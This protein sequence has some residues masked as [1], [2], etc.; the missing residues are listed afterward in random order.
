M[1]PAYMSELFAKLHVDPNSHTNR[2]P[3]N[4]HPAA[5]S[6]T[7]LPPSTTNAGELLTR[8]LANPSLPLNPDQSIA[9]LSHC[10][11]LGDREAQKAQGKRIV[12]CIGNT[13]SGKSTFVNYLSGCTMQRVLPSKLG[14]QDGL[15][16]VVIVKPV[17]QGGT[18]DEVAR[19]G[20]STAS[21]TFMPQVT[22][23]RQKYDLD[24][25]DCP[26]FIDNR[27]VEIN[28]A[29]AANIHRTLV[30]A[31][32]V[33]V[34]VLVHYSALKADKVRGL[35]DTIQ[36]CCSLFG[37]RENLIKNADSILF[38]VS[39]IPLQDIQDDDEDSE[40]LTLD[41]LRE[42]ILSA[43]LTNQL[44]KKVL[45]CL[46][47]NLFI[48]DPVESKNLKFEGALRRD[49]IVKRISELSDIDDPSDVFKTVL[50]V[51]DRQR[52]ESI[53]DVIKQRIQ[54]I[55][56]KNQVS[57]SDFE[58]CAAHYESLQ[59][60]EIIEN[61]HIARLMAE[62][63]SIIEN[64]FEGRIRQFDLLVQQ[65]KIKEAKQIIQQIERGISP[66]NGKVDLSRS[67]KDLEEELETSNEKAEARQKIES[68]KELER[69]I[70]TACSNKD[71]VKAKKALKELEETLAEFDRDYDHLDI[72]HE[73]DADD[74]RTLY[75]ETKEKYE[76][77]QREAEKERQREVELQR[78]AAQERE[79]ARAA[80]QRRENEAAR[81]REEA[82]QARREAEAARKR[83]EEAQA[84]RA[85]AARRER[86]EEARRRREEEA[87]E[88]RRRREEE[89]E[90]SFLSPN[91][92]LGRGGGFG[93]GGFM[94]QPAVPPAVQLQLQLTGG[95]INP[96]QTPFGLMLAT[97]H[98]NFPIV[99]QHPN[100]YIIQ[101]P[102]GRYVVNNT[103]AFR[104]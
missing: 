14:L 76:R 53:V 7:E 86:E 24:L 46:V 36:T 15:G 40:R 11:A 82:A 91:L 74:L 9:L 6:Y 102:S 77:K 41:D 63:L 88:R 58:T 51:T 93:G 25:C 97:A 52:L 68:C 55:L 18:I 17:S 48:Y 99:G 54:Q 32:S 64:Y 69:S 5:S 67:P 79:K 98:G 80:A 89:R 29:N 90:I 49:D 10:I 23:I 43:P 30:S 4:Y 61:A 87:E 2:S 8:K 47:E 65:D 45:A 60:L 72:D 19:I 44:E 35:T 26:G 38:G 62:T 13:G 85:A 50:S 96:V 22:K 95:M 83:E 37:S 75:K 100:G 78:Q 21:M 104:C 81:Q 27:D 28:A 73:I 16:K 103:T 12:V 33:R 94:Q 42:E 70:R 34:V 59:R 92:G 66:F 1:Q 39:H 3:G 101:H 84:R 31:S 20:H 56:Q 71:F 57:V